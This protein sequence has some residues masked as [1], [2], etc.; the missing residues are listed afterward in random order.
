[1]FPT[2]KHVKRILYNKMFVA[3]AIGHYTHKYVSTINDFKV[4]FER[5]EIMNAGL[6]II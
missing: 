4:N 1:M 5:R 6:S 3:Y 2:N